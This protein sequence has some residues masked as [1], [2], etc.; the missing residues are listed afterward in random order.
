MQ[1]TLDGFIS[2]SK[3]L[4]ISQ[5]K[6]APSTVS[7]QGSSQTWF[8]IPVDMDMRVAGQSGWSPNIKRQAM[9]VSGSQARLGD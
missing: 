3:H 2:I 4:I 6:F 9:L 1:Q 5:S 8:P 7:R